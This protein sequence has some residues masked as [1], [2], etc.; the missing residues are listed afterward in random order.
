MLIIL[1]MFRGIKNAEDK[2]PHS[3]VLDGFIGEKRQSIL[4][5]YLKVE[6]CCRLSFIETALMYRYIEGREH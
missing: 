6:A 3:Q 2:F 5:Q 1:H 4:Y